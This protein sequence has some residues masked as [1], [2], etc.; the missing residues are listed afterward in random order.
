M[1]CSDHV[2]SLQSTFGILK[3][4][5][6]LPFSKSIYQGLFWLAKVSLHYRC[7]TWS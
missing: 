6:A 5:Y 1:V 2:D 4:T 3:N 7:I